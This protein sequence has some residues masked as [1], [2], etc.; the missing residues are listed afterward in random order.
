[1]RKQLLMAMLG[2]MSVPSLVVPA[3][4]EG[5]LVVGAN[6]V[7]APSSRYDGDKE[8]SAQ[9][10]VYNTGLVYGEGNESNPFFN[11]VSG[12][13]AEDANGHQW[14]E[15]AY[16][17]AT[18]GY[19][20]EKQEP[21]K[22]EVHNAP[23][24]SAEN[25]NGRPSYQ[26][27]TNEV[28][29]DIYFR[30]FFTTDRLL[31][32]DVYLSCGHD[33]APCE[34]YLNG[35]L[36]YQRT[37]WEIDH[38]NYN[39]DESG[40]VTDSFPTYQKGWDDNA[41]VKLTDEQKALIKLNGEQ[42]MLAVHVH[43]NWG[44]AF[45]DCGLY[46][47]VQ[48]GVDMGYVTPWTGKVL[49]NSWGGYDTGGLHDW[50]K[51]YEAQADDRYTVHLLGR[52]PGE[53]GQQVH[54]KSPIK[55]SADKEYMLKLNLE[56]N[57]SL[58]D[59]T[60]KVTENDNDEV[61][62]A[63]EKFAISA[64][65]VTECELP[66]VGTEL[67]NMKVVFNFANEEKGTDVTI[68]GMSLM[69]ETDEKELWIGTSYFNY[70]YVTDIDTIRSEEDLSE[71]Y[72]VKQIKDP[73][74]DGR[75]ETKSWIEPDF[76]DSM[77]S[78]QEMPMGNAGYMPELKSIWPGHMGHLDY[79]GD[80]A[81]G[82]N[83]NYWVRRTFTLDKVNERL[84]YALNVCHDDA[85]ETY[86]NGHLLQ[87]FD[88]WT[89]GK[90]P[91]QV[92]IPA[93]YLR[94]GK[95]VIATYIQ[96][97]FGGRFYDCGINVEEVNYDECADLLKAAIALGETEAPLTKAM[98]ANLDSLMAAGR[99]ELEVNKDAAELKEYAKNLQAS[100]NTI[101]GYSGD[102][103]I[104]LQTID[105]CSNLEDKGYIKETLETVKVQI[106]SCETNG[107][108]NNLLSQ[109]RLARKLNALERHT[110]TFVGS[111]P[112]AYNIETA[113]DEY[114]DGEYFIYNVGQRLFLVGAENW[115]THMGLAY[116]SNAF[117]LINVNRNGEPLE[118]GY[119]I[120][121][122]RPN[123]TL[124]VNDFLG[125]NGYVDCDVDQAWEFL[126]VEGKTNVYNIVRASEN[127]ENGYNM[128][129]YR[130][131]TDNAYSCT[132]NS[133]NVVDTDMRSVEKENN[134]WMLISKKELDEMM[135]TATAENPVEATHLIKNPGLDQRLS[136]DSWYFN[137]QKGTDDNGNENAG[138]GVFGRGGN[139][140]DFAVEAWNCETGTVSQDIFDEAIIPGWYTLSAQ[141]YYRDGAY[142]NHAAK[143]VAGEEL[144][145]NAFLFAG[146]GDGMV[147]GK[148]NFITDYANQV[149]GLGR[150]DATGTL[151]FPD[152]CPSATSDYFQ[153]GCYWSA[154]VLFEVTPGDAT[155][156]TI[157]FIKENFVKY[158]WVVA[159]N[160]RLKYYG[161][162]KPTA[163]ENVDEVVTP[164][165]QKENAVYNLQGQ[166][167]SRVQKGV[168][169]IGGKKVLVK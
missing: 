76:D 109:L 89:D 108:T 25:Y 27:T 21:I 143:Y 107:E 32:G 130:D 114:V 94:E 80:G 121:T 77:W 85:Y 66:I 99:N 115:G 22:W 8:W 96:Q 30:R 43:Q 159:D 88:G 132:Y 141:I 33:D 12:V 63:Q 10:W 153:N 146:E 51:L 165:L 93:K 20:E 9:T 100:I 163:I 139:H 82:H 6:V 60:I 47:S 111:V 7:I 2:L 124:G 152:S 40:E 18:V 167:L 31:S 92:H 137:I 161:T 44:G 158:D 101:L 58:E 29:A 39:T 127:P 53:W 69:D 142:E 3:S 11:I 75:V 169:I 46:T 113:I 71:T 119:R 74:I 103:N 79:Q 86:V 26:W 42:N 67:N 156:M 4:A 166:R 150:L 38:W 16:D 117:R 140:P 134:Q 59:V 105:I 13:P 125:Y 91:K 106:D 138:L 1:M 144:Q 98:R 50:E 133:F 87:K 168:N 110:E 136:I 28:M 54:F 160:F 135:L 131:G 145:E 68:S 34:Y 52:N 48:G 64:G 19:N 14:Y 155:M 97:N 23:F 37:G 65:E 17:T 70:C 55:L 120:Q 95:N 78:D 83:T 123:G 162:V 61:V 157:G 49:F 126:P 129:G 62:G 45:A 128:L 73:V 148:I 149:P 56:A 164:S 154:P 72:Q 15:A 5:L 102:V 84:S 104:L 118:K 57:Q 24:H 36:I 35:V 147:K 151:R 41:Y 112:A 81:E 90:N 122:M 116:A